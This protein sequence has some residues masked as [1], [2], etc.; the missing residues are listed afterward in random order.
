MRKN[1]FLL[2]LLLLQQ[3]E[4][5]AQDKKAVYGY[6]EPSAGNFIGLEI[7]GNYLVNNEYSFSIFTLF[8]IAEPKDKPSNYDDF[9][10]LPFTALTSLISGGLSMG[11]IYYLDRNRK[12]RFNLQLG[13][14]IDFIN[15][16]VDWERTS[17]TENGYHYNYK[18]KNKKAIGIH[19]SPSFELPFSDIFGFRITPKI[20]YNTVN[21]FY[22]GVGAGIMFG[23]LK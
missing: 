9:D 20:H 17:E 12:I 13:L 23:Y 21:R 8:K 16:P 2:T 3:V 18:I 1:F 10:N 22:I 6:I 14:A 15:K 7:G 4:F 5:F 19:L 11:K